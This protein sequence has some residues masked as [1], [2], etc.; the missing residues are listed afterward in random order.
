MKIISNNENKKQEVLRKAFCLLFSFLIYFL[1]FR[2][3]REANRLFC[4]Y[5]EP[6]LRFFHTDIYIYQEAFSFPN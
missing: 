1:F 5:A 6:R 2:Y 4:I 3:S